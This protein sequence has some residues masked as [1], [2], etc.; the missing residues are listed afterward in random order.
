MDYLKYD[1]YTIDNYREFRKNPE[2]V[3]LLERDLAV[4]YG[5][6][7]EQIWN[8]P[9]KGEDYVNGYMWDFREFKIDLIKAGVIDPIKIKLTYN[10]QKSRA[11][12]IKVRCW[13]G[14]TPMEGQ[15]IVLQVTDVTT[16][17]K[18]KW[19]ECIKDWYGGFD[20]CDNEFDIEVI[21]DTCT[22]HPENI[23]VYERFR[24]NKLETSK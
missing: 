2:L 20:V 12:D 14:T 7:P 16:I 11:N 6:E 23:P 8:D 3:K 17:F 5:L 4:K 21:K 22:F 19:Y 9:N 18:H 10:S 24:E 1:I 13:F 15:S